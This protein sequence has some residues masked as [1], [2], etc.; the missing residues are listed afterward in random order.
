M[1][2]S[3]FLFS[4]L[5]ATVVSFAQTHAWEWE[6]TPGCTNFFHKNC[7][8]SDSSGNI[9]IGDWK[10]DFPSGKGAYTFAS[11]GDQ[12]KYTGYFKD[13]LYSG[14][15]TLI[16][17]NGDKYIGEFKNSLP[18]GRGSYFNKDGS[19]YKGP[20]IAGKRQG[21]G[22]FTW[23]NGEQYIRSKRSTLS[24]FIQ[25]LTHSPA[26]CACSLPFLVSR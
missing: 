5:L 17:S 15:G 11:G 12:R 14:M 24:V 25:S 19:H 1:K 13:G 9:Y 18:H 6:R 10:N 26:T 3:V 16:Y 8:A 21:Y 22:T 2:V 7:I 20:F 23:T 4:F